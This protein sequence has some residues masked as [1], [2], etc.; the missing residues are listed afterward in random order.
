[1]RRLREA[2]NAEHSSDRDQRLG[3]ILAAYL[4]AVEAGQAPN[5]Q[6]LL[7][8]HPDL[9]GELEAFFA[10]QAQL[11]AFVGPRPEVGA[12]NPVSA[13]GSGVHTL[14]TEVSELGDPFAKTVRYF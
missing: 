8:R 1:M 13:H 2:M 6:E 3:E 5:Q 14:V 9:A 7:A 4:E 11:A 12:D 10:N